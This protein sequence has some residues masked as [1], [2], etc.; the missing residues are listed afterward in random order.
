MGGRIPK[1][2]ANLN[3]IVIVGVIVF[4]HDHDHPNDHENEFHVKIG[5]YPYLDVL[6]FSLFLLEIRVDKRDVYGI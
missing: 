5:S 3:V 2:R 6:D 1:K 4:D